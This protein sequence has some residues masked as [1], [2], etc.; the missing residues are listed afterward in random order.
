MCFLDSFVYCCGHCH[1]WLQSA[2]NATINNTTMSAARK[3]SYYTLMLGEASACSECGE[4]CLA[5]NINLF[6]DLYDDGDILLFQ[7]K[8]PC[9]TARTKHWFYCMLCH[10]RNTGSTSRVRKHGQ[11]MK[12]KIAMEAN[13][14]LRRKRTQEKTQEQATNLAPREA[15]THETQTHQETGQPM[16]M[17]QDECMEEAALLMQVA[18]G[19]QQQQQQPHQEE[20]PDLDVTGNEWLMDLC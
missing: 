16:P 11:G 13:Q 7:C 3:A 10:K 8:N 5:D 2:Q 9:C 19:V 6:P 12:H 1:V 18:A 4:K 15:Q 20:L 14:A 17:I